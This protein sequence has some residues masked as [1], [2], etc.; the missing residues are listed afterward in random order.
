MS[1][2][3]RSTLV[4]AVLLAGMVGPYEPAWPSMGS[5]VTLHFPACFSSPSGTQDNVQWHVALPLIRN[6]AVQSWGNTFPFL[7]SV[8]ITSPTILPYSHTSVVVFQDPYPAQCQGRKQVACVDCICQYNASRYTQ[9][10]ELNDEGR[11]LKKILQPPVLQRGAKG[12]LF[13]GNMHRGTQKLYSDEQK[14]S[15][16]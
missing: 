15:T 8:G 4:S 11:G 12:P 5:A 10:L 9:L 6:L 13:V 2:S 16:A 3:H 7:L 14:L 1:P